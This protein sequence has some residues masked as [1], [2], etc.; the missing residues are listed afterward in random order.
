M[1]TKLKAT[2]RVAG[3]NL[4]NMRL[5][6]EIPA[7]VYGAG[8]ETASIAVSFKD[9]VKVWKEAGESGTVT[10]ELPTGTATVLIHEVVNDPVKSVPEHVDFLAIDVNK[11]ITVKVPIE[12]TGVSGAVKGGLGVLV[13]VLHEIELK[14]LPNVMPHSVTV[15]I[16]SLDVLDSHIVVGDLKLPSG[17]EALAKSGDMVASIS[18]IKEEKEEVTPIDFDSIEVA[19]KGKKEEEATEEAK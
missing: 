14:G 10:L 2:A 11:P 13:K 12:F 15:D 17:V 5:A 16:S 9:F 7:V 6:G 3:Q 18:A 8:S 4:T 1:V 19:K